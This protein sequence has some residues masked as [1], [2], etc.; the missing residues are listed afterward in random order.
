MIRRIPRIEIVTVTLATL[1]GMKRKAGLILGNLVISNVM[2]LQY[3]VL[4]N[5]AKHLPSLLNEILFQSSLLFSD[6][7][8]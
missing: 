6:R 4:K 7:L 8:I 1:E 2:K 5:N 3:M